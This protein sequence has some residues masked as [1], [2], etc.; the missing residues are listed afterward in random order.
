MARIATTHPSTSQVREAPT[1]MKDTERTLHTTSLRSKCAAGELPVHMIRGYALFIM[2]IA[3][4]MEAFGQ[5]DG[6]QSFVYFF[7][8]HG[9]ADWGA[10]AFLTV[11]GCCQALHHR[12]GDAQLELR[13]PPRANNE[14]ARTLKRLV[15]FWLVGF[16]LAALCRGQDAIWSW[17]ILPLM[18]LC[19]F[20]LHWCQSVSSSTI[21][22]LAACIVV[23]TPLLRKDSIIEFSLFWGGMRSECFL[24]GHGI[25]GVLVEATQ[26]FHSVWQFD[27][28]VYGLLFA[29]EFPIFPWIAHAMIG[30]VMGRRLQ[31]QNGLKK[32]VKYWLGIGAA[33]ILVSL[34][35]AISF[36]ALRQQDALA[37]GPHIHFPLVVERYVGPLSFFPC[38]FSMFLFQLGMT[39]LIP[40][41]LW[42]WYYEGRSLSQ[43]GLLSRTYLLL[44]KNSLWVYVGHLLINFFLKQL[45]FATN[46]VGSCLTGLCT[47]AAFYVAFRDKKVNAFDGED[48]DGAPA[49]TGVEALGPAGLDPAGFHCGSVRMTVMARDSG[50]LASVVSTVIPRGMGS[51]V[52]TTQATGS[53]LL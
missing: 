40:Y 52:L 16:F 20:V 23:I 48:A 49:N 45:H 47:I 25:V 18:G 51:P 21:L 39:F 37:Q 5:S 10:A 36:A 24:E 9:W 14:L 30:Y 46:S 6:C 32:D 2:I 38:S 13:A 28:I 22:C 15:L 11:L 7:F 53:P 43:Y 26:S 41:G 12:H 29:G 8:V 44:S 27:K 33:S 1:G 42:F 3:H 4:A 50:P 19:G 34:G 17:D 35:L 31:R